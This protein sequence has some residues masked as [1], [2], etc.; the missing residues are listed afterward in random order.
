MTG[1]THFKK[2]KKGLQRLFKNKLVNVT[3]ETGVKAFLLAST[4]LSEG[5]LRGRTGCI[6]RAGT[7]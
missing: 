4:H 3:D 1:R 6:E 7:H 2:K 5:R